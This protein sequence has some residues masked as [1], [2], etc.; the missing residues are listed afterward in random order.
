MLFVF[1]FSSVWLFMLLYY[2]LF[3][4]QFKQFFK[5][6]FENASNNKEK[7]KKTGESNH[8][9]FLSVPE[10]QAFFKKDADFYF[11][12]LTIYDLKARHAASTHDYVQQVLNNCDEFDSTEQSRLQQAVLEADSF[13]LSLADGKIIPG[14]DPALIAKMQWFFGKTKGY[15]YE[16]G[17][18]HTR[19]NIIF[20]MAEHC[21]EPF[22]DL[23][24]LLIHEKVHVYQR[25]HGDHVQLFVAS[26]NCHKHS[27][28]AESPFIRANPDLDE[29]SYMCANSA[30]LLEY[31]YASPNPRGINDI[32]RLTTNDMEHPYE[33]MAYQLGDMYRPLNSN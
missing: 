6:Y 15:V 14:L 22:E 31:K 26:L 19:Q 20:L 7:V 24:R 18:P 3:K 29:W 10:V 25:F 2:S 28:R 17:L 8:V 4:E 27:K 30:E 5:E 33:H 9:N 21:Q 12:S 13:F 11:R 32:Q 23:V 16:G 1:I